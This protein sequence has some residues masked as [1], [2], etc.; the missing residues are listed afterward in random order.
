M[1]FIEKSTDALFTRRVFR[2]VCDVQ[3]GSIPCQLAAKG[4][5]GDEAM[6]EVIAFAAPR[7]FTKPPRDTGADAHPRRLAP[8]RGSSPS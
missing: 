8:P 2:L 5:L 1:G 3:R 7:H 4:D 6:E